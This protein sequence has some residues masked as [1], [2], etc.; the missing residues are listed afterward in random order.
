MGWWNRRSRKRDACARC[1]ASDRRL[2]AYEHGHFALH[3]LI[4][5]LFD[6]PFLEVCPICI[7]QEAALAEIAEET[8][9]VH[10]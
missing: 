1:A 10:A 8:P 6:R 9:D 2:R 4:L 7:A 5:R 3:R